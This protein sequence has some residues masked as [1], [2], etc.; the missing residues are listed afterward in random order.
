MTS[1]PPP[2][3]GPIHPILFDAVEHL[4]VL[5]SITKPHLDIDVAT[6]KEIDGPPAILPLVMM[7][8]TVSSVSMQSS[9]SRPLCGM[10]T[11]SSIDDPT[12]MA[13]HLSCSIRERR[14]WLTFCGHKMAVLPDHDHT[15]YTIPAEIITVTNKK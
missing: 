5:V 14:K 12:R 3:R 13:V 15:Q 9:S 11:E 6:G 4:Q 1:L 2:L 10:Q 7:F 8:L